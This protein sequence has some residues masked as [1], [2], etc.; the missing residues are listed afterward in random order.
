M[1]VALALRWHHTLTWACV[2]NRPVGPWHFLFVLQ[3]SLC[4]SPIAH[5]CCLEKR[6]HSQRGES[7]LQRND[8]LGPT[9]HWRGRLPSGPI[10]CSLVCPKDVWQLFHPFSLC[11]IQPLFKPTHYDLI[12]SFSL[13]IPLWICR[14]GISICYVQVTAI[15]PKG[16]TVGLKSIVRDECMRDS[17]L[18]DNIFPNKSFGIHILDI[19]QWFSFNTL[20]EVICT[21]Q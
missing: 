2:D 7:S 12:D 13:S 17:K 18:S 4:S 8:S 14:G 3:L 21:D 5:H 1:L 6:T 20:G 16:F 15:P 11:I 9:S 19:C 10:R